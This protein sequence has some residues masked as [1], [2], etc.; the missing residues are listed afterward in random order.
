MAGGASA[1]RARE[2]D[3][4]PA[5]M[6]PPSEV[7]RAVAGGSWCITTTPDGGVVAPAVATVRADPATIETSRPAAAAWL[8]QEAIPGRHKRWLRWSRIGAAA[9]RPANSTSTTTRR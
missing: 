6:V 3:R 5:P 1:A 7:P 9:Q 8:S 2:G 4:G